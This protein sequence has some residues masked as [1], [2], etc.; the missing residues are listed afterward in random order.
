[1]PVTNVSWDDCQVFIKKLNAKTKG[2]FILLTETEWE[3]SCRAG[4]ETAYS[5]GDS[6]TPKDANCKFNHRHAM[7][8]Y[9]CDF[10]AQNIHIGPRTSY[11]LYMTYIGPRDSKTNR[12][13][14]PPAIEL[15]LTLALT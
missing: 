2:G 15:T 13:M 11:L 5:F 1:M 4:T 12:Q 6:V 10:R 7:S 14:I 3:Y 8:P 9:L